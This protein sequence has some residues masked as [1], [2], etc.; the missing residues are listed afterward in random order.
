MLSIKLAARSVEILGRSHFFV[1]KPGYKPL[2]NISLRPQENFKN[3]VQAAALLPKNTVLLYFVVFDALKI[4][5]F[6]IL[7]KNTF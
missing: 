5:V 7:F 3:G 4:K 2:R 6:G 1:L